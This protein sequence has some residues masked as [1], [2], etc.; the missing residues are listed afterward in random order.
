[1]Y[2]YAILAMTN[3]GVLAT[4]LLHVHSILTAIFC[5]KMMSLISE[6][7]GIVM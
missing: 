2:M 5:H 6:K 4:T 7:P 3:V 1:M